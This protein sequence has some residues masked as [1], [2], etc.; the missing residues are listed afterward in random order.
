MKNKPN[1]SNSNKNEYVDLNSLKLSLINPEEEDRW[2]ELMSEHHYLGF[3][4]I[5][6]NTLKY[7]ATLKE[8]W[9]ALLG[10]GSASLHNKCRDEWIGWTEEQKFQRLKYVANNMR[11]LI[12]PE[13]HIK[14]LASKTLSLN[15]RR[16]SDDWQDIFNHPIVIAE[17]FVEDKHFQGTCYKAANW[18]KLGKTK[19]YGK[20][21]KNYYYH[22]NIKT[23]FIYPLNKNAK[24]MLSAQFLP[25]A[26]KGGEKAIMDI[27]NFNIK[28]NKGLLDYLSQLTDPRK[29]RGIRHSQS[30]ILAVSICACIGGARS[31]QAIAEWAADLSQQQLK[32]FGCREKEVDGKTV[33]EPPSEP[34]IRRMLKAVDPEEVDYLIGNW[35]YDQYI[36]KTDENEQEYTGISIDGKTLKGSKTK[37]QKGVHLLSALVHNEKVVI[38]QKEV[39]GK[40][41]EIMFFRSLIENIDLEGKVVTADAMH[42]QRGHA[43]YLV[44]EKSAHYIFQI[45]GNQQSVLETIKDID[46]SEFNEEFTTKEKGHGRIEIRTIQVTDKVDK[47]NFPYARQAFK[48]KRVTTDLDGKNKSVEIAYYITSIPPED[49][50]DDVL[51]TTTRNHWQI[52]N[53]LHWVRD[54][55]FDEDRSQIRTGNGPRV[56]ASLRNLAISL[57]HLNGFD[58]I[59]KALRRFGRKMQRPLQLVGLI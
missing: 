31:Y 9:V 34:T 15:L 14:N 33:Y 4:T 53:C 50:D 23:V 8:R 59:A 40:S 36:D 54:V 7:V 38:G 57:F 51:L 1:K 2:N 24:K 58:N 18:L 41:N 35:A 22:G 48:I 39:D 21:G 19:G 49:S 5:V 6:G 13:V 46:E 3:N 44:E 55:T 10:W 37:S 17:T 45:K 43:E 32:L 20:N 30:S 11:F 26:L 56:M 47:I 29:K 28:G 16:L 12:L 25:P 52:E 42:A 27:N